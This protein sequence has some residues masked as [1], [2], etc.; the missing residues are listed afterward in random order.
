MIPL[1]KSPGQVT[2][3]QTKGKGPHLSGSKAHCT[4]DFWAPFQMT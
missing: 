4:P 2:H 3:M 1:S